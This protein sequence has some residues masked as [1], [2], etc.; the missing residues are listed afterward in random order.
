MPEHEKR[1]PAQAAPP[2]VS[3]TGSSDDTS[4]WW[5]ISTANGMRHALALAEIELTPLGIREH[6]RIGWEPDDPVDGPEP[7]VAIARRVELARQRRRDI[8]R[9]LHLG[10]WLVRHFG[11]AL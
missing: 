6:G 3:R 10:R 4:P 7:P 11:G 8:D 2:S 5:L 1:R 9:Q